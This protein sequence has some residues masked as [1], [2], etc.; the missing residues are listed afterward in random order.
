MRTSAPIVDEKLAAL[1]GR[2]PD[3][4]E[5]IAR[6]QTAAMPW[7]AGVNADLMMKHGRLALLACGHFTLTKALQKAKCRRCGEMIRAGYDYDAFRN[8]GARDTFSWPDDP[9]GPLHEPSDRARWV[10]RSR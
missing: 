7:R 5:K 4:F 1:L 3:P 6:D 2:E 9:L 10:A 8:H